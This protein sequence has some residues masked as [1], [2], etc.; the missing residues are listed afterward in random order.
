MSN[1][2]YHIITIGSGAGGG[3]LASPGAHGQEHPAT[4]SAAAG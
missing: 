1:G 4:S 2:N 3:T